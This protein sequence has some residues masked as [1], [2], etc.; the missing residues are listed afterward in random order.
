MIRARY[1]LILFDLDGVLFDFHKAEA[2]ALQQTFARFQ[3]PFESRYLDV[4][5]EIN[6]QFWTA[7]EQ[8]T[9]TPDQIKRDRFPRFMHEIGINGDGDRFGRRYL[10]ELG[11]CNALLGDPIP[12]LEELAG[13]M[14]LALLTNGLKE[15]QR[16]RLAASPVTDFFPRIFISEELGVAKPDPAIFRHALEQTGVS[17][18][19]AVLMV[20]DSLSS[21][22]SGGH[23]AGLDTCWFNPEGRGLPDGFPSPTHEIRTLH[24]LP[25][26]VLS[27]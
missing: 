11:R 12:V 24:D 4:Y 17:D 7:F 26:F 20:G 23:E 13:H 3:I 1:Q 16:N 10:T 6:R 5:R 22:I 25:P 18:P 9:C 19:R 2:D 21:D 15:V 14:K 27:G 8:G